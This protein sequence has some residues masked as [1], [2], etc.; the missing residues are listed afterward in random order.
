[1]ECRGVDAR[2]I[3]RSAAH[4]PDHRYRLLLRPRPERPSGCGSK[5]KD[6]FPA[7]HSI[8]SS[9][10]ARRVGGIERLRALAVRRLM[11]NSS[12]VGCSNGK[13]PGLAP[14][15]IRW[16]YEARRRKIE[17]KSGP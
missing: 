16:T 8:T 14:A 12:F 2:L 6:D 17:R 15:A 5:P 9:A 4:E 7:P 13:S 10:R 3:L 1:M 11:I